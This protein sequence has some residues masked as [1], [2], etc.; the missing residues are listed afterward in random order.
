M[1][2]ALIVIDVQ[3]GFSEWDEK[4]ERN[5]PDCEAN[6]AKLIQA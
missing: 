3:K 2:R 1:K 6:V 5:N 4:G